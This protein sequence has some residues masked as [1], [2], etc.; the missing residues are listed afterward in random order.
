MVVDLALDS[1]YPPANPNDLI[2]DIIMI[3]AQGAMAY[4]W[5]PGGVGSWTPGHVA[6]LRQAGLRVAPIIVPPSSGG[7]ATAMLDAA[8]AFG[9]GGGPI[10]LDLEPPNLP[11]SAWE[12]DFDR[13]AQQRGF[14]DFDYGAP[15]NLGLYQPDNENWKADW[16]RT[17]QLDPRP[18]PPAGGG[19]QF[20]NGIVV[21]GTAYD[22]SVIDDAV[23]TG[24]APALAVPPGE[25][26]GPIAFR[27]GD[28]ATYHDR[29]DRVAVRG[30]HLHR[31]WGD[32][33]DGL[34]MGTMADG[35][36]IGHVDEGAPQGLTL[37][38]GTAI[39]GWSVATP[40]PGAWCIFAAVASDGNLWGFRGTIDNGNETG[41]KMV[42]DSAQ[43]LPTGGGAL[44][45]HTHSVSTSVTGS[46]TGATGPAQ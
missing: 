2:R 15:S 5:R 26:M 6:A 3:G 11:T 21:N 34:F 13:Q 44:M 17:G 30:G 31:W 22:A 16:L 27:P 8:N 7:D 23:F 43:D 36:P 19:W 35:S 18:T 40:T 10:T 33:I 42:Q 14:R 41:W 12:E 25:T 9:F 45:P 4:V 28:S 38:P 24:T 29:Y 20:V 37:I 32:S 1:L 39:C 46:A